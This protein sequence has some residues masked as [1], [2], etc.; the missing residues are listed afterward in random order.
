MDIDTMATEYING[1]YESQ[2]DNDCCESCG[3]E[4][5]WEVGINGDPYIYCTNKDCESVKN[6]I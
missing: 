4:M 2:Y 3:E 1:L 5:E 6:G